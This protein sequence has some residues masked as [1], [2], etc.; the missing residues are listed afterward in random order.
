MAVCDFEC[1]NHSLLT[2]AAKKPKKTKKT[3]K[4]NQFQLIYYQHVN[5]ERN[6]LIG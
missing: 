4:Q 5:F 1:Q 3:K 2:I 6:I